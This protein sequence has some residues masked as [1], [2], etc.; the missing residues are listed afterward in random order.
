[1]TGTKNCGEK[2]KQYDRYEEMSNMV[3]RTQKIQ[4]YPEDLEKAET[5]E[6]DEKMDFIIRLRQEGRYIEV[7]EE[8]PNE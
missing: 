7:D 3:F 6:H 5:M 1:M 8:T 2:T 4:F